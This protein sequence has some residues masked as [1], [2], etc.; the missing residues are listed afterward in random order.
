MQ[1]RAS[2]R[3]DERVRIEIA[4]GV[5]E[6]TLNRPDKLNALDPAMFEA[7]IAA[8]ENLSRTMGL[9]AIVLAGAGK[10]FCAGLDKETFAS[11]VT[12][13]ARSGRH[14]ETY[15]WDRQRMAA[16]RVCLAHASRSGH[17]GDPWGRTGRRLSNRPWRR[18]PLR[19][20]GRAP[21]DYGNQMGHC[22][23]HGGD[24]AHA[25]TR[26]FRGDPR[27]RNDRA[28]FL[29]DGGARLWLRH[30]PP[31]RSARQRRM[32]TQ[33]RSFSPNPRSKRR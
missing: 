21:C 19:R 14:H 25:R 29:R 32:P 7:I 17:R 24:C 3:S 4:D 16:S 27:A 20:A 18:H 8:G 12:K 1:E 31:R 2:T 23:R 15:P 26:P 10:G 33:Q 13:G 9:R 5:A 11:F 6:V 22:S 28:H 30:Q